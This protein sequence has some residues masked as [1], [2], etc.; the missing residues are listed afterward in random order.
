[1]GCSDHRTRPRLS[2]CCTTSPQWQ[3]QISC[4]SPRA[5]R[6]SDRRS[7]G[8]A[9][10]STC[11][12]PHSSM[13]QDTSTRTPVW[14]PGHEVMEREILEIS[15]PHPTAWLQRDMLLVAASVFF[16]VKKHVL[17]AGAALVSCSQR[18]CHATICFAEHVLRACLETSVSRNS[19]LDSSFLCSR[20]SSTPDAKRECTELLSNGTLHCQPL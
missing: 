2:T 13:P 6:G 14:L 10:G 19:F 8:G 16:V 7:R 20:R 5:V 11:R 4:Q 3:R 1:M 18:A 15:A 17:V 9:N 12:S